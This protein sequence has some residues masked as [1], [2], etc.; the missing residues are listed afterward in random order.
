MFIYIYVCV[1][2]WIK[3]VR[4]DKNFIAVVASEEEEGQQDEN[5]SLKETS[6][7]LVMFIS[8]IKKIEIQNLKNA[9]ICH[10]ANCI[11]KYFSKWNKMDRRI[12]WAKSNMDKL[13]KRIEVGREGVQTVGMTWVNT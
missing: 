9:K 11:Y 4:T 7:L 5:Q 1:C 6:T 3:I 2:I 13:L 10:A 8:F 12:E